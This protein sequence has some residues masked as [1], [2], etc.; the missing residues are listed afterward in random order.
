MRLPKETKKAI[1]TTV[2][3]ALGGE[4][5]VLVDAPS[6]SL[7]SRMYEAASSIVERRGGSPVPELK[8]WR[9][10]NGSEIRIVW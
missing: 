6:L 1:E 8:A 9:L 2:E 7:A 5:L 4:C 10:P 3:R